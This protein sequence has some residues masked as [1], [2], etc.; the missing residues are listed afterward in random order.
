MTWVRFDDQFPIHRKIG[1]LNDR[2]YRLANEAIFWC[3]RNLTDGRVRAAELAQVRGRATPVDAAELVQR[4]IWHDAGYD[5]PS[6][7]C[8]PSGADG[9]AIHDYWDYQP[10]REKVLRERAAKAERQRRWMEK[11]FSKP[12]QD[13]SDDTSRDASVD[14][15]LTPTPSPS[16]TP[17]P[18]RR[19]AGTGGVPEAT[20]DRRQAADAAADGRKNQNH[21]DP[22]PVD[23]RTLPAAGVPREPEDAARARRGAAAARAN[24]RLPAPPPQRGDAINELRR[25]TDPPPAA[26]TDDAPDPEPE[27]P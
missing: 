19:E 22:P 3:A 7:K 1:G 2:L 24:I 27:S 5:C 11:R 4:G 25:L 23:W 12:S 26:E 13:G 16:P 8:P 14:E 18:P 6:D 10:S 17:S 9:W 21:A 15:S 20:A